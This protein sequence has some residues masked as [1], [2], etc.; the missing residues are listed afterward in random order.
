MR[1]H[2]GPGY[3]LYFTLRGGDLVI[4]LM[5]GDKSSQTSDIRSAQKMALDL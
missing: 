4:L 1:I 2:H 5:G 3:R